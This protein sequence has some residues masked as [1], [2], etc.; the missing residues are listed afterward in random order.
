M[1][2][3]KI[4]R[5]IFVQQGPAQE[6]LQEGIAVGS[7]QYVV[8]RIAAADTRL[9]ASDREQMQVMVAEDDRCGIAQSANASQRLQRFRP[10]V[11]KIA[12]EP[13]SIAIDREF[14]H[15]QER[16]E[17]R[18][19][20]LNIADYIER[21]DTPLT[22]VKNSRHRQPER[23]DRG[24]ELLSVVGHHLIAAL[25]GADGSLYDRTAGVAKSLARLEVR[26]L[27]DDAVAAGL[28]HVAVGVGDD[29]VTRQQPRRYLAFVANGDRVREDEPLVARIGLFLDVRSL[30]RLP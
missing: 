23:S 25:H 3:A 17:F 1:H 4:E 7:G 9:S 27:A 22:S 29:P 11:D 30:D 6:P 12:D 15:L 28:F 5:L 21:Q 24:V 18:V 14:Q 13:E 8:E 10:A 20:A 2:Q 16:A 19:T 26:L